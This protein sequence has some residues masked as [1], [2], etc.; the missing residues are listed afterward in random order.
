[1]INARFFYNL[2][3]SLLHLIQSTYRMRKTRCA[4]I[5]RTVEEKNPTL[6]TL[7]NDYN[8][9]ADQLI[10]LANSEYNGGKMVRTVY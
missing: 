5:L 3:S 8:I 2:I 10:D 6:K 4:E 1:M 7:I 9:L